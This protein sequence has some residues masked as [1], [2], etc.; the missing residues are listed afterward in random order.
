VEVIEFTI[1]DVRE[2]LGI[3][4]SKIFPVIFIISSLS[5][6]KIVINFID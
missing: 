6:K 2:F 3:N 4:H 1:N 5:Y